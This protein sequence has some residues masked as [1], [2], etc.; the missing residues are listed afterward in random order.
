MCRSVLGVSESEVRDSCQNANTAH[1]ES[2][3]RLRRRA[4]H[5]YSEAG[6]VYAFRDACACADAAAA[7]AELGRLMSASHRSC[8]DD[9]ECSHPQLDRLVALAEEGGAAGAR[10]TG[11][12]WGGCAV[13]LVP[14]GVDVARFLEGLREGY[15]RGLG[16]AAAGLDLSTVAFATRPGG[17][18]SILKRD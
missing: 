6:R 16:K 14:A 13:A 17:G 4:A 7:T 11:A 5:V 2:G 18:A 3:F 1:L 10:L 15:Y 12:G 8:R 9:Y